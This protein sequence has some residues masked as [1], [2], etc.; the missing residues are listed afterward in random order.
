MF[1]YTYC[2]KI[3]IHFCS[4]LGCTL[5]TIHMHLYLE[6]SCATATVLVQ[7]FVCCV[8]SIR[9]IVYRLKAHL[10]RRTVVSLHTVSLNL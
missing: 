9:C 8:K 2:E 7:N 5:Y 6:S 4:V 10:C 1:G 3:D